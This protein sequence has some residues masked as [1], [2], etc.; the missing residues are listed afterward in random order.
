MK[1][2][3]WIIGWAV[4]VLMGLGFVGLKTYNVDPFFHYHKPD[5][6]KYF[7]ELE[8]ERSQNDGICRH[9][10]YDAI[11]IGSSMCQNFK[12]SE[13]DEIFGVSSIKIPYP[14][15]TYR[16]IDESLRRALSYNSDIKLIVRGL[17][18]VRFSD[19]KDG[20]RTDLGV[21]PTYLYDENPLNDVE[22]L[23]N[24][25][26][27]FGYIYSMEKSREDAEFEPGITS[28]DDYLSFYLECGINVIRPDG[29]HVSEEAQSNALERF[30]SGSDFTWKTIDS[31][32]SD[33]IDGG[34]V[35]FKE[36]TY[37]NILQNV[38][39]LADTY[40]DVDF[41]YFFT[42]YSAI[43]WGD[44]INDNTFLR[45]IAIEKYAL[46]IMLEHDNIKVFSFNNMT[47]I[48][49]DIDNYSDERHYGGWINTKIL[50]WM[51]QGQGRITKKNY[52]D[53]ITE[54]LRFYL[55]F[56]YNVLSDKNN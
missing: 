21:F 4:I 56:N 7:Y 20:M 45:Q 46:E 35:Y 50:E 24:R 16:E 23:L 15:A 11:I 37:G 48:T 42:P 52:Q 51:S 41:Y 10:D 43:W 28:F 26:L 31:V 33:E 17:D 19:P 44:L 1:P 40:P 30:G 49:T 55:N 18:M 22:Y 5:T 53:Y 2:M 34:K 25:E 47:N 32:L 38:T 39:E 12:T 13:M 9:F 36:W 3:K 54:E 29:V 8:N 27:L 6:S 14:G